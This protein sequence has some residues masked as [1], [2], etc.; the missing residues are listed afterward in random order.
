MPKGTVPFGSIFKIVPNGTVPFGS[1]L[2]YLQYLIPKG[3]LLDIWVVSSVCPLLF[4]I[5][6]FNLIILVCFMEKN[7]ENWKD[8][9]DLIY[10]VRGVKVMLDADLA[11]IY[12]YTTK[13]F[14][15]QV[16]NNI[17]KFDD[18]FRFKL[19][20]KEYENILRSKNLT[21]SWGGTRK[22]PY[23]FT[24]QGI[25][26]LM[27]VLKGELA[28]R[29][30][31]A[32]IR[33]FKEMKDFIIDNRSLIGNQEILQLSVQTTQNTAD[34][35]EIKN[36]MVTKTELAKVI[37]DFTDPKTRHE[38]L[39]L[40]GETVE[41]N[42]AYSSIYGAAKHT[43]F[44]VDNYIGLKTLVLLKNASADIK[45][46]V[47]SDNIGRGLHQSDY[48]DFVRQYP[49]IRID[50]QRTNGMYHDRYII[51]D[52]NTPAEK[53]YHCG[54]SSKDSGKKVS[55]IIEVQDRQVYHPIIDALIIQPLLQLG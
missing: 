29:Q 1:V 18:D 30:S 32:L 31:K 53:I 51:L 50:F 19:T 42:L 8:F 17:E 2:L 44:V 7:S 38:Y 36:N 5:M 39:I 46:T 14:N 49:G 4:D 55:T 9:K 28:T 54:A 47:F 21:S 3:V 41:A 6:M 25:Y 40:N 26:M 24:E 33:T 35:A 34:I 13:A 37:H 12:G 43:I 45:I 23:V 27:T 20:K 48:D 52:Y 15:Q 16:K 22:L 11:G 10:V